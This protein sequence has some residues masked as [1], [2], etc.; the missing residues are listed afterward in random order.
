MQNRLLRAL[1]RLLPRDFR[2]AYAGDLE[3]TFRTERREAGHGAPLLRLWFLTALD[4]MRAAPAQHLDILRRDL[5]FAWRTMMA[6]PLHTATALVTLA[7]GLGASIAMFAVIDAVWLRP[8]PYRDAGRLVTLQELSKGG[9]GSNL[10]Y[11]TF[12]DLRARARTVQ[13][14]TAVTQSYGTIVGD[15][16]DAERIGIMR[17]SASYFGLIG[18]QPALGRA[19][20]D[21]EDRPGAARRVLVISDRLWRRR[22]DA[23][24]SVVNRPLQVSGI[25]FTIVGVMPAGFDDLVA[26]RLYDGAEMWSPLGYD[27]AASFACRTCRHLRV[28]AR[29]APG[30]APEQADRELS[31]LV[32]AMAAEHPTEYDDPGIRVIGFGDT[33]FGSIRLTLIVLSSGVLVLLL[34]ACGNVGNLLLLRASERAQEVAIRT[35][36]GVTTGRL[37]RQLVTESMLLA[38]GGGLA[39]LPLAFVA[40]RLFVRAGPAELPR[41]AEAALDGRAIAMA[42]LLVV[43]SGLLFSL[44][45]I[46]QLLKRDAAPVVYGAGRRTAG[47]GTWRTRA[48]LVGANVA[49]AAVLLVGSGLLVRS[50]MGL[51]AVRTGFDA[52]GV[53]TL[54]LALSG[55][56]FSS[57]DNARDIAATVRFYDEALTR[58][59]ALPGVQAAAGVTTLP[60]GGGVDG[61]GLHIAGRLLANPEA[62]PAA[63]RFVVTPGYFETLGIRLRRGRLLEATD[64]QGATSVAVI[65]ETLARE[66]FPGEDAIGHEIM[67]GPPDAPARTI[68]GV[69]GDVRHHGLETPQTYQVYVPQAQ[70]AWAETILTLVVRSARDPQSLATPIRAI[71]K[72]I[73]PVQ[74]VTNV[75]A[76]ADIVA[77]TTATRRV[78]AE[79]LVVFATVALVL[80]IVGLYGALGVFVGQRQREI[81]VRLALGA[82]ATEIAGRVMAQGMRPAVAGLLLGLLAAAASA[83]GV[84]S[85]L[86]GVGEVDPLTFSLAGIALLCTAGVAC[87]IPAWRASRINPVSALRAE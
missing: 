15:G 19:F 49:M 71:V 28:I 31:G 66:Q 63:D 80:A 68:V 78:A 69:V 18:V 26:L 73:D 40:V 11:L 13:S 44:V 37:A 59:R 43:M 10:G 41:L 45:P 52:D 35:A 22:F 47:A 64:R 67:L 27:P 17:V 55:A 30:A 60:L 8:L 53:L 54:R 21:T 9:D 38:L 2:Q 58:I 34:V 75:R 39:G 14:M 6:R 82:R 76:Y 29:L 48:V 12:D 3:T 74:P 62:A 4:I 16:R 7:L 79:L 1:L 85:L 20:T 25:P 61:Y 86:Y 51:L 24:P 65:N 70:W 23:D 77:A 33:F 36:L 84:R 46:W 50:L 5:R 72:G 32:T 87:A 81:G 56:T 42:L 83:R 57:G